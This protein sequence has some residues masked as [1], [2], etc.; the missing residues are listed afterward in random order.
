MEVDVYLIGLSLSPAALGSAKLWKSQ[1]KFCDSLAKALLQKQ[2]P[3]IFGDVDQT[4]VSVTLKF[5]RSVSKTQMIQAFDDA[6]LGCDK[7]ALADFNLAL[8]ECID[9]EKGL[10]KG[11]VLTFHWPK[12]GGLVVSSSRHISS[13][14]ENLGLAE[15]LLE[16]YVDDSRTVSTDLVNCIKDNIDQID[17][18]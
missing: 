16:V 11:D 7:D 3:K 10:Q 1:G 18:V 9:K 6:L 5:M 2:T 17:A 8:N 15:R 12:G 13:G 14:I 4:H